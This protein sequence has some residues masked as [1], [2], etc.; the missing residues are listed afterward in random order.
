M[1]PIFLLLIFA[2]TFAIKINAEQI[3]KFDSLKVTPTSIY[4]ST[5]NTNTQLA[6]K[7]R[8][9]RLK[10][11]GWTFLSAGVATTLFGIIGNAIDEGANP[12]W[13]SSNK[14]SWNA[15][16]YSGIAVGTIGI[17]LLTFAYINKKK[18]VHGVTVSLNSSTIHVDLPIGIEQQQPALG[19]CFNF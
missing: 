8:Y 13:S 10:I 16:V 6:Y 15:V 1:K 4:T 2:F 12:N 14:K 3:D 11:S 19:I 5:I 7:T 17:P 18:A 9:K